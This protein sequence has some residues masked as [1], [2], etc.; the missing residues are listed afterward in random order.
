MPKY[1]S[2]TEYWLN[3]DTNQFRGEFETMYQEIADPWGCEQ[4]HNSRNNRLFL[5]MLFP[6][7]HAARILDIGCGTGAFTQLLYERAA[8]CMPQGMDVLGCDV[9]KTA[10]EK[11]TRSFENISFF[12]HDIA[13]KPS[14]DVGQ[15]NLVV[16]SEVLWYLLENLEQTLLGI[17]DSVSPG[18]MFA[19][20]QYFPTNQKFGRDVCLGIT[21]FLEQMKRAGYEL[22]DRVECVEEHQGDGRVLLATFTTQ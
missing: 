15:F 19:I 20:H 22:C 11:A 13:K 6:Q 1:E 2:C 17:R 10:V 12:V 5:E 14:L 9:S 7:E 3:K 21:G 8:F 16:M 4:H 18:G